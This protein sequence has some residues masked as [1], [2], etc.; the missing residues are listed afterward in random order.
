MYIPPWTMYYYLHM[1]LKLCS[2]RRHLLCFEKSLDN[3]Q[4]TI[5]WYRLWQ[6]Q[7]CIFDYSRVLRGQ[8]F[9]EHN[10][11]DVL[12]VE[13]EDCKG[14]R[15]IQASPTF[16]QNTIYTVHLTEERRC[17][18]YKRAL[19]PN[20]LEVAL[21]RFDWNTTYT[22]CKKKKSWSW[23]AI[24]SMSSLNFGPPWVFKNLIINHHNLLYPQ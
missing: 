16:L 24:F 18:M 15:R 4:K 5:F 7:Q 22:L 17:N 21:M 8:D 3:F 6:W 1:L 23:P 12:K 9:N 10:W 13:F 2:P 11:L 14:R 19:N 20:M